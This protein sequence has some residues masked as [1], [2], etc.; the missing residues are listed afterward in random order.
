MAKVTFH[1]Q[2]D[3]INSKGKA[4]IRLQFTNDAKK[5]RYATGEIVDPKF[6]DSENQ[7]VK[8]RYTGAAEINDVLDFYEAEMMRIFREAKAL[9]KST[10]I[11][12]VK[13][14]FAKSKS[15]KSNSDFFSLYDK[16]LSICENTRATGTI[17]NYKNALHY[18]KRFKTEK[19][20]SFE[21]EDIDSRF[22]ENF[23]Q[24]L[25]NTVQLNNNTIGRVI[26]ILKCFLNWA[27]DNNYHKNYEFKKFKIFRED[28]EIIYLTSD[29]LYK[30]FELEV[31]SKPL[32]KVKDL[33]LLGCF[34]GLRFSDIARLKPE[35][36]KE[37]EIVIR[38]LKTK[39]LIRIPLLPQAK[40]IL[41]KHSNTL[42]SISH[43]KMN[44]YL[45]ELCKKAGIEEE[46]AIT[47]YRGAL[48]IDKKIPKYELVTSHTARRTF[49]TLSLEKGMRP[50]VIMSITG[51]KDF[52]TLR[53]YIKIVDNVKR[54]EMLNAWN[55]DVKLKIV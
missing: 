21:F 50:E 25:V 40:A 44:T 54:N 7:R 2:L 5:F 13:N 4:P 46:V 47:R 27:L 52:K 36:I 30:L 24:Y 53:A 37:D 34:T 10:S 20:F 33:F 51:H 28:I 29:E 16:F 35:N 45:K 42:P 41:Q 3:K 48:R 11:D 32:L 38:T 43:Q 22:N 55:N 23:V 19:K 39:D 31:E 9:G 8:S 17:K 18:F 26:K 6:W 1:L 49:V 14:E 12:Y 15:A